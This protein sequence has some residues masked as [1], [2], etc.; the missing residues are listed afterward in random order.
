MIYYICNKE[1]IT[2]KKVT[3]IMTVEYH[4]MRRNAKVTA[5]LTTE[6][7]TQLREDWENLPFNN[8]FV[9]FVDFVICVLSYNE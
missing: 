2:D 9:D 7:E 1:T 6:Q 8:G 4:S 3:N 5:T